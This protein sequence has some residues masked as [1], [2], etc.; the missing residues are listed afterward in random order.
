V[1]VRIYFFVR[2]PNLSEFGTSEEAAEWSDLTIQKQRTKLRFEGNNVTVISKRCPFHGKSHAS[3]EKT[4][5]VRNI[6]SDAEASGVF[7][8]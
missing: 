4:K 5:S 1:E 6:P 8:G 7:F 2:D 3:N